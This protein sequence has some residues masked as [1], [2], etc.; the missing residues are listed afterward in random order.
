MNGR[1]QSRQRY[2]I[3]PRRYFTA[4]A[5]PTWWAWNNLTAADVHSLREEHGFEG[6]NIL[7][8]LNH[9]IQLIRLVGMVV[10]LI[11]VWEGKIHILTL[12]D[13]SGACIEVK[14][15]KR[16]T[17][18]DDVAEYPSNTEIDNVDV[19]VLLGIPHFLVDKRPI[20]IGSIVKVRGSPI[21]YRGQRQLLAKRMIELRSTAEE[22]QAWEGT[23]RWKRDVLS[24]PWVLTRE[25]REKVDQELREEEARQKARQKKH[26]SR[27]AKAAARE[28]R[29]HEKREHKRR[30]M[31][32]MLN[33]GALKGSET[34]S[35]PW[36]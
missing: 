19:N 12:D 17:K 36:E 14:I 30:T 3:Y 22:I 6:Q 4:K 26:K 32:E 16:K 10:D 27:D 2:E 8:H 13:G 33:A 28:A 29:H 23:A 20:D 31:E 35:A 21:S 7:F 9:P 11:T 1:E 24:K 5:S 18:D 34:I 15:E 25:E